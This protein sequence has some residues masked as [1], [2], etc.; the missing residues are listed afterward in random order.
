MA[1]PIP[2]DPPVTSAARGAFGEGDDVIPVEYCLVSFVA[3]IGSGPLGGALAHKLALRDRLAEVRI[4]DAQAGVAQGKA[5]DILQSSPID[6]FTTRVAAAQSVH[7]AAGARAIVI[8]DDA[9]TGAEHAG[10]TGLALIRQIARVEAS[11][12]I[13]FAGASQQLLIGGVVSELHVSRSRALGTAPGALESALRALTGIAMD[14]SG[15]EIQLRVVGTPPDAA[16]VG[17]EEATAAGL[18]VREQLAPH[19]IAALSARIP[20]LWPPGPYALA[21]A[22]APVVEAIVNGSRRRF[23]CFVALESG[24][25][26]TAVV[27]MPVELGPQGVIRVLDP[28]L[29]RKERTGLEGA[30]EKVPSGFRRGSE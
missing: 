20:K 1:N 30:I 21:S 6:G 8:A 15:A 29:T 28:V 9:A 22:A 10:E 14:A 19:A 24:P 3:V 23:S 12:P 4:I 27:S 18:P 26:R 17:W 25:T 2:R 13:V 5:L 11:A 7:A 16:V